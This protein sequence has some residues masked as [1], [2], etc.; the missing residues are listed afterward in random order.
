MPYMQAT[1]S[2]TIRR[3]AAKRELPPDIHLRSSSVAKTSHQW[4]KA[5]PSKLAGQPTLSISIRNEE[6]VL[7]KEEVIELMT[8]C[9]KFLKEN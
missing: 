2:T 8:A 1:I 3:W 6:A 5:T 4:G 7:L 9:L